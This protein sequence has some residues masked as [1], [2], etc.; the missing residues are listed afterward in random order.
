MVWFGRG[1]RHGKSAKNQ[2]G[3]AGKGPAPDGENTHSEP[4]ARRIWV[5]FWGKYVIGR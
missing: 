4:C 2:L 1:L 3:R 5:M